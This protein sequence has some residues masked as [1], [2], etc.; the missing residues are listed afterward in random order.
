MAVE[1]VRAELLLA[2]ADES[3][4]NRNQR[5]V[6]ER[7][8]GFPSSDTQM[9]FLRGLELSLQRQAAAV[10]MF[11]SFFRLSVRAFEVGERHVQPRVRR[12][13]SW[14][15]GKLT[16]LE[17]QKRIVS[18]ASHKLLLWSVDAVI[19]Q[20]EG[21]VVDRDAGF[22]TEN[23]VGSNGLFGTHMH[24]RHKPTRFIR[25]NRQ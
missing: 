3:K 14:D 6:T 5:R 13:S 7:D 24:G 8:H 16:V 21:S 2:I 19:R 10:R 20:L 18:S 15:F 12:D 1:A 11:L 23:F 22:R 9:L 4:A 25:S 17:N